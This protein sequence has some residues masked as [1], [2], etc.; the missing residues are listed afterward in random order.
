MSKQQLIE[1]IHDRNRSANADFLSGFDEQT[2]SEYL[3]RLTRLID[4]RGPGSVW[5]RRSESPCV[6]T[7]AAA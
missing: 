2:L 7:R 4:H 3:N 5:E 1:A 6:A